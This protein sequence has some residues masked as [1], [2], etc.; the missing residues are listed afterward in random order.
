[1][2][3]QQQCDGVHESTTA[4]AVAE[5]KDDEHAASIAALHAAHVALAVRVTE[6]AHSIAAAA[7]YGAPRVGQVDADARDAAALTSRQLLAGMKCLSC[8]QALGL[9]DADRGSP[10]RVYEARLAVPSNRVDMFRVSSYGSDTK[11]GGGESVGESRP[12][13]R[14]AGGVTLVHLVAPDGDAPLHRRRPGTTLPHPQPLPMGYTSPLISA[15]AL[16]GY[17]ALPNGIVL[18]MNRQPAELAAPG[19][20]E[21]V[22][23]SKKRA[24]ST[25]QWGS[26]PSLSSP[27]LS[28]TT[29][30]SPI[31][32]TPPA[33]VATQARTSGQ[34][35]GSVASLANF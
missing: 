19:V 29:R 25:G 15:A 28:G 8:D 17:A 1:L 32:S 20:T 5:H 35:Q 11:E 14:A 7:D 24:A 13:S 3:R 4:A 12:A 18:N 16:G 10:V 9:I 22:S 6:L 21:R 26:L 23:P 33:S 27:S 30:G 31:V 2:S 34:L